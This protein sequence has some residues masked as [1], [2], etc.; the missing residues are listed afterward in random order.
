MKQRTYIAI[1]LKAFTLRLSI[2][3]MGLIQWTQTSLT[4]PLSISL[5]MRTTMS[6]K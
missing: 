2:G 6:L 5:R 3:S 1:D 4:S